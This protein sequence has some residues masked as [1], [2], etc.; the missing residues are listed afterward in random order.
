M[1]AL[2][3]LGIGLAVNNS[4]AVVSGLFQDGGVFQRTP[5]YCIENDGDCWRN[6]RYLTPKNLTFYLEAA[7]AVY[8][9]VCFALAVHWELWLSIPFIYLFLHGYVYMTFLGL[10]PMLHRPKLRPAEAA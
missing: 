3:G 2:M 9:V 6:K 1:P 8:F 7:F 4:R 5:K 10:A